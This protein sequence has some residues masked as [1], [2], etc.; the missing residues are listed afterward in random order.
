MKVESK[1]VQIE[2]SL[3]LFFNEQI[4]NGVEFINT[5]DVEYSI[6]NEV[7]DFKIPSQFG[8]KFYEDI[9]ANK[10]IR[11]T[12]E[13]NTNSHYSFP[14]VLNGNKKIIKLISN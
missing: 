12:Y 10:Y 2:N 6:N 4:K 8:S 14:L 3:K 11:K 5:N 9:I 1:K 7:Y 13:M